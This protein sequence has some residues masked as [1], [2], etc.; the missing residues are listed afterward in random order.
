MIQA[1]D[2]AKTFGSKI[3]YKGGSFQIDRGERVGLVGS[4]GSGKTT[5]L[6]LLAKEETPDEGSILASDKLVIGYFSQNLEDMSGRSALEEVESAH[7]RFK[8]VQK[9]LARLEGMFSQN[10]SDDEMAS[11]LESYGELQSEFENIGGYEFEAKA[12]EILTG[13][14]IGPNRY[15][16]PVENF[17]GGWKMRIALAKILVINPDLLLMDEPTNHLDVESIIWLEEW[18]KE[19]KGAILMTCHDR[20]FMN[21]LVGRVIEVANKGVHLYSGNYDFYEKERAIR[22]RN[23]ISSAKK[24]ED[25]LAKDKEFIARFAAR[26]SHAAQVQ[27]RVKKLEK[28]EIIEIPTEEKSLRFEW[29][30]TPRG[31]E[32]VLIVENLAKTWHGDEG[33]NKVFANANAFVK[34]GDRIAVI[35]CNGAGK[36]TFMKIIVGAVEATSGTAKLGPSIELGYFSQNSMDVLNPENTIIEE[37]QSHLPM[38]NLGYIRNLLGSLLFSGD[39]IEKKIKVLSGGE[40]SRL[41]L[42]T[43]MSRP[44]NFL[45]LDEPTNHLD[46]K[47][48][49]VLMD[50]IQRFEGTVMMVS[51][52]RHFLRALTNR[53]FALDKH[54]IETFDGTYEEYLERNHS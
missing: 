9:E 28:I 16:Q 40:K 7:P 2:I 8:F 23:L 31:G 18:L 53:V 49:E 42:A 51:H 34:R 4:N 37:M 10:L 43:I 46:I 14:G 38:A 52:D 27:S 19:F 25:M 47:S 6:R 44:I 22:L 26:A 13:L 15:N 1:A 45:V 21:R 20:D 33:E 41:V 50:A 39:D 54:T 29:Q 12:A 35:G 36:S 30:N 24:Q 3:L 11:V 5:I 32:Q 17:S 48:R